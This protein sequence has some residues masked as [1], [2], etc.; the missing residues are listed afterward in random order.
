MTR[1]EA[2][3]LLEAARSGANVSEAWITRALR[4]T[5]DIAP[6]NRPARDLVRNPPLPSFLQPEEATA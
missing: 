4:V 1:A 3:R 5:G 6:D 2:N